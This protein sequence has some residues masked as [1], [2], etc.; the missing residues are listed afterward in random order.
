MNRATERSARE[1]V[2][3]GTSTTA[4]SQPVATSRE[5]YDRPAS[6][7]VATFI[8]SPSVDLRARIKPHSRTVLVVDTERLHFF[9]PATGAAIR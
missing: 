2:C 4:Q 5:L 9:D 6:V 3:P 7:L 8:G 1:N